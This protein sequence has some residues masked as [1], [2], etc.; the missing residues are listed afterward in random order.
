MRLELTREG[1]A[2]L[3]LRVILQVKLILI[4]LSPFGSLQST[5]KIRY[6]KLTKVFLLLLNKKSSSI[7]FCNV[8]QIKF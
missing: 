3:K 4:T 5:A 7:C 1:F 8:N 2:G 6:V